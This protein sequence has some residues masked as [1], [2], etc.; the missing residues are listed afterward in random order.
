[1]TRWRASNGTWWVQ[2]K[3]EQWFDVWTAAGMAAL[4]ARLDHYGNNWWQALTAAERASLSFFDLLW[5]M[6]NWSHN[7]AASI[8]LE[9]IGFLYV[10]SLL[11]QSGLFDPAGH[12]GL[13]LARNYGPVGHWEW[14]DVNGDGRRGL[15]V[16]GQPRFTPDKTGP[17]R[18]AAGLSAAMGVKFMALLYRGWLTSA[19]SSWYM[20]ILL[21]KIG[22]PPR[23]AGP[24]APIAVR[25]PARSPPTTTTPRRSTTRTRKSASAITAR[26]T[27][28]TSPIALSSTASIRRR[29]SPSAASIP[30]GMN[31][32]AGW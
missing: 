10:N 17:D 15:L 3:G 6:V 21:D 18:L 24:A 13:F 29:S 8:I 4:E 5:M 12:G 20:R 31:R 30:T 7:H 16:P 22:E 19:M 9:R 28:A 23:L 14:W 1:M 27:G 32:S 11:W 25:W 2:F 26:M